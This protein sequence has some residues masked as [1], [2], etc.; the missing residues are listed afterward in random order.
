MINNN[1]NL[2]SKKANQ[3]LR[4]SS[5]NLKKSVRENFT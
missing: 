1:N 4:S 5:C 3:I 2:A